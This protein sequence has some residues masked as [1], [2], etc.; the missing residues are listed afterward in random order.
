MVETVDQTV[1]GCRIANSLFG[2]IYIQ[3]GETVVMLG[4]EPGV[5]RVIRPA[6][7]PH[8]PRNGLDLYTPFKRLDEQTN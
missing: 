1:R 4:Y 3:P 7:D 5:T 6:V 8:V 2:T